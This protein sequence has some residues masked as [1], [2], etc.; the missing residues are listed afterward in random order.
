MPHTASLLLLTFFSLRLRFLRP[1]SERDERVPSLLRSWL[2]AFVLRRVLIRHPHWGMRNINHAV[3]EKQSGL[4]R[5]AAS[6]KNFL[7]LALS[8]SVIY[9]VNVLSESFSCFQ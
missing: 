9:V 4:L 1:V 5:A 7:A 8:I 3:R 6:I 2:P